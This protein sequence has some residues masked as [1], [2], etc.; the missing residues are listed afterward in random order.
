MIRYTAEDDFGA[1]ETSF[2]VCQFWYIDALTLTGRREE[3]RGLFARPARAPQ[4]VRH[5]VG[6]HPP[7][8][9]RAVGMPQTYS[10]AGVINSAMNLSRGW[11]EAWSP[12][13]DIATPPGRHPREGNGP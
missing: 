6:R 8:D 11:E 12:N 3:A 2:L 13:E 10:M 5:P 4:R 9:R 7:A 1:P